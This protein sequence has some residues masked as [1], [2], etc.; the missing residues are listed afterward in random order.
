MKY[1]ALAL[2]ASTVI[3]CGS[4]SQQ[5]KKIAFFRGDRSLEG[6]QI[7]LNAQRSATQNFLKVAPAPN[8]IVMRVDIIQETRPAVLWLQ[9]NR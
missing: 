1:F 3:G 2:I 6:A 7:D 4:V 5:A 9:G 8:K